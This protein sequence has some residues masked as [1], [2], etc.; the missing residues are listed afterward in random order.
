MKLFT[1]R[2]QKNPVAH[3]EGDTLHILGSEID[4]EALDAHD[5][6]YPGSLMNA[7]AIEV[8]LDELEDKLYGDNDYFQT[9]VRR[10]VVARWSAAKLIRERALDPNTLEPKYISGKVALGIGIVALPSGR[11]L[12]CQVGTEAYDGEWDFY[13]T[14]G[15]GPLSDV[16]ARS[17]EELF[18]STE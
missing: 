11:T 17:Y 12:E 9:E 3:F 15:P 7:E 5:A 18:R 6:K 14:N 2:K 16:N 10:V 1:G 8:R 13:V 4:F